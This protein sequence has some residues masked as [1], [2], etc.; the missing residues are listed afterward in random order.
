MPRP[1]RSS[2]KATANIR[3]C[4]EALLLAPSGAVRPL[5][6]AIMNDAYHVP[7]AADVERNITCHFTVRL[8]ALFVFQLEFFAVL[9]DGDGRAAP[10]LIGFWLA[11]IIAGQI[12]CSRLSRNRKGRRGQNEK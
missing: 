4:R 8:L 7:G 11:A 6:G 5:N 10:A 1:G 9:R 2:A 12:G 3:R